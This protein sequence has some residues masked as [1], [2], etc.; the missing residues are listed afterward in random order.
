MSKAPDA[1]GGW[2]RALDAANA[3]SR[4]GARCKRSGLAC[5]SPAMRSGRCRMH[6]GASTGARTP[7]GKAR[8]RAAP[9]KHGGRD[10]AARERARQRGE[11][12]QVARAV[13]ALMAEMGL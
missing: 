10:E 2:R 8:C 4:C 7:G 13:R 12:L 5:R 6:G 11:A 3:T 9:R 1:R